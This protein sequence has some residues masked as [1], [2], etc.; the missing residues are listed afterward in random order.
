MGMH[1]S[2]FFVKKTL[3]KKPVKTDDFAE[4]WADEGVKLNEAVFKG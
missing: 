3:R 2:T 1:R 4:Y